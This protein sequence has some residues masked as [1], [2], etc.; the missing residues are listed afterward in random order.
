MKRIIAILPDDYLIVDP[1]A[2]SGT[3]GMECRE[4]GKDFILI[5]QDEKYC[6]IIRER[7]N[8]TK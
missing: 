2:G 4:L 8:L 6:G 5:E 1:F 7:L 3:T